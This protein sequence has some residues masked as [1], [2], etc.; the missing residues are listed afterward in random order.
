[1]PQLTVIYSMVDMHESELERSRLTKERV[2][3]MHGSTVVSLH[4]AA[5]MTRPK[6]KLA[7]MHTTACSCPV[8]TARGDG[9]STRVCMGKGKTRA[10]LHVKSVPCETM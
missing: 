8:S 6:L 3:S 7:E 10:G 9:D 5:L 1:M 2:K 4:L